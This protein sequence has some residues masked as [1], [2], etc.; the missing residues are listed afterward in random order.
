MST[1]IILDYDDTCFDTKRF[2]QALFSFFVSLGFAHPLVEATY[3][4]LRAHPAGYSP[5]THAEK[6][7]SLVA[8]S[9]QTAAALRSRYLKHRPEL[10]TA[11]HD[12]VYP[13]ARD[14]IRTY[15]NQVTILTVGESQYQEEKVACL[16]IYVTIITCEDDCKAEA[17]ST[18]VGHVDRFLFVDNLQKNLDHVGQ[19]FPQ[20][21]L[22]LMNRS[23]G[24]IQHF[25][26]ITIEETL[27][28]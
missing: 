15:A 21:Q 5:D 22:V 3:V 1:P 2:K 8:R 24:P 14:F 12:Y 20:A 28:A 26:Q 4:S 6:L 25:D 10:F 7:I 18:I 16:G 17:L 27:P 9:S 13:D 11:A 23:E 19:Q